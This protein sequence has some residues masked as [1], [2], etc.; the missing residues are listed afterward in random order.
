VGKWEEMR[1]STVVDGKADGVELGVW[2]NPKI[3]VG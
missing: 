3:Y 1:E 2:V